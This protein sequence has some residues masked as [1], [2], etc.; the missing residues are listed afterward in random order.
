MRALLAL[1]DG[2]YFE[3]ESFGATGTRVGEICFNTAMTG[4]QE[5]L[6]DPSYRGQIVTM[7]YPLIGNYGVNEQ[8]VESWRPHV[9][10]FVI[11]ELSPIVSN[12][13]ADH[14]LA[15]YLQTNGIPGIQDIDTRALTKK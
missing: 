11:R 13:R 15:E 1:E 7:T 3:G 9:A 14:T 2:K 12:W 10:G 4:Y 8:D 6:T 5:I